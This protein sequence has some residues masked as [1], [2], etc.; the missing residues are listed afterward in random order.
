MPGS[1]GGSS[2]AAATAGGG[3]R[4]SDR[5]RR[6]AAAWC[7]AGIAAGTVAW[8]ATRTVRLSSSPNS[9]LTSISVRSFARRSSASALM[10]SMSD[11]WGRLLI[12]P[13]SGR[14]FVIERARP[15]RPSFQVRPVY[16]ERPG[17]KG[18]NRPRPAPRPRRR[19]PLSRPRAAVRARLADERAHRVE[20]HVAAHHPVAEDEGRRAGDRQLLGERRGS[21]PSRRSTS[22][23]SIATRI[24]AGSRPTSA[25]AWSRLASVI[26]PLAPS[27]GRGAAA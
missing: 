1:S 5:G 3:R 19:G 8:R 21:R 9:R 17:W 18:G 12:S 4:R 22:G 25:S 26:S 16:S 13:C 7:G 24:A 11:S 15:A 10:N 14:A 6:G 2:A 27:A 23:S 20:G